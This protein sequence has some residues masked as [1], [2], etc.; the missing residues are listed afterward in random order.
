MYD[1]K[2]L[3][4]E[5]GSAKCFVCILASFVILC[6]LLLVLASITRV[7]EPRVKIRSATSNQITH[8][9]SPSSPSFNATII[10]FISID[11]PNFDV[12]AYENCSVS[13]LYAGVKIGD[14]PIN[15]DK[16]SIRKTKEINV[17]VD[18][19]SGDQVPVTANFSG[20][21]NSGRLNLTSYAKFTGTV[22]F[23]KIMNVKKSIQMACAMKLNFTSLVLQNIQC[24]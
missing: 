18:L 19:R 10:I 23:L 21:I 22:R 3:H 12:F 24:Q 6:A 11:N 9:A 1:S 15:G 20:D 7:R 2:S 4:K 5:R 16:V 17:T 8:N 14:R 13:V